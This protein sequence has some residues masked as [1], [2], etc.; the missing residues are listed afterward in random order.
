MTKYTLAAAALASMLWCARKPPDWYPHQDMTIEFPDYFHGAAKAVMVVDG[1]TFRAMRV[2]ADDY[3]PVT[4]E[5]RACLDTQGGH[6]YRILRQ[7]DIIFVQLE[8]DL[9]SC[10]A[11]YP[12][13]DSTANYAIR[14]RDGRILRRLLAGEFA[15]VAPRDGGRSLVP[16]EM[17]P[18]LDGGSVT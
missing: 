15:G 14:A 17:P 1:P 2:A 10:G 6:K 11:R 7:G 8:E 5:P 12:A 18:L 4:G 9:E 3:L 16:E 13:L